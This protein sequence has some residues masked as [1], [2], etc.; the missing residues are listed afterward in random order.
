MS[1]PWGS[2]TGCPPAALQLDVEGGEGLGADQ[3]VHDARRVGVVC[4]VVEFVHGARGVLEALVPRGEVVRV[5]LEASQALSASP[6]PHFRDTHFSF[7][8]RACRSLATPM[9]FDRSRKTAGSVRSR[10]SET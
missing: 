2:P 4:A 10:F 1:P 8:S 3:V 9:G 6:V 7:T 5:P